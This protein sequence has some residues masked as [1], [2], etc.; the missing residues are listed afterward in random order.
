MNIHLGN[1]EVL[2]K[3]LLRKA[4]AGAPERRPRR[5]VEG[6]F[7]T[8][9]RAFVYVGRRVVLARL[10]P[11]LATY[12]TKNRSPSKET[13]A[14]NLR[15][16]HSFAGC[17]HVLDNKRCALEG[18]FAL[19]LKPLNLVRW[20]AVGFVLGGVLW[21]TT[22]LTAA[23]PQNHLISPWGGYYYAGLVSVAAP[24]FVG[25]GMVGLHSLQERSY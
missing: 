11:V 2:I 6:R 1:Q 10:L 9:I 25:L 21:L 24:L 19:A 12:E 15:E 22:G 4:R 5:P 16:A 7:S 18:G 8:D 20:G 13:P 23:F 14:Q 3:T 17:H